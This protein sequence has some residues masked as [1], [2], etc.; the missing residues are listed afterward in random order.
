MRLR[1]A[2]VSH[3]PIGIRAPGLLARSDDDAV[4][5]DSRGFVLLPL[6]SLPGHKTQH[7]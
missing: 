2:K 6:C 5:P 7:E 1:K 4:T 3:M